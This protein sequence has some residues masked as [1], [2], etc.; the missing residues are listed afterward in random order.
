MHD[1][2]QRI[3][4]TTGCRDSDYIPKVANAG[5]LL[6]SNSGSQIQVMHN[7]IKVHADQYYGNFITE[8]IHELK[9]HHEPQEEKV[10]HEVLPLVPNDGV[11][12][13]LG[14]Y[15]G[16]YSLWFLNSKP[17]RTAYLAEPEAAHIEVGR[18]NFALNKV[19]GTFERC[20]IGAESNMNSDPPTKT[21]MDLCKKNSIDNVSIL[22]SDIQ[23]YE[24]EMLLGAREL[25][26]NPKNVQFIF[27][28]THGLELHD[29]C[30]KFLTSLDFSV[31]ASHTPPES[32]SG[33]GL[34][35][36][37]SDTRMHKVDIS[38]RPISE[39][40]MIDAIRSVLYRLKIYRLLSLVFP[41]QYPAF[42]KKLLA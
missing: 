34:I 15:W 37:T 26:Q 29:R 16:Y 2:K 32:Y 27:I 38:S 5:T 7:G 41:K 23:G 10:F 21:V 35:V 12:I 6:P 40:R 24:F 3:A 18:K 8:I 11:M 17:E 1:Q 36:V 14:A 42:L 9:G 33:D 22:H 39:M 31:V 13:E 20:R 25:L 19:D 30:L 4:T 28:S